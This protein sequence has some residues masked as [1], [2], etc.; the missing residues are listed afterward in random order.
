MTNPSIRERWLARW[1]RMLL[2]DIDAEQRIVGIDGDCSAFGLELKHGAA[3]VDALPAVHSLAGPNPI[4]LFHVEIA[5]G[6][7]CHLSWQPTDG[8]GQ[9]LLVDAT[10]EWERLQR[11]Q[12]RANNADLLNAQLL[13]LTRQLREA[14]R[15]LSADK[16]ALEQLSVA[17]GRL[18]ATISHE[19][20]TPLST[21]VGHAALLGNH[22]ETAVQR[23][24]QVIARTIEHTLGLLENLIVQSQVGDQRLQLKAEPVALRPLLDDFIALFD[25]HA[26]RHG[27]RLELNC[28]FDESQVAELDPS[29][30][31]QVIYNLIGNAFKHAPRAVVVT[32]AAAI[33]AQKLRISIADDGDGV[34]AELRGALFDAFATRRSNSGLGLWISRRLCVAMNGDLRYESVDPHGARFIVELNLPSA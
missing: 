26:R 31:R 32:V 9:W 14:E 25:A 24:A 7:H 15:Q 28:E 1:R 17:R 8:G 16:L 2:I 6:C 12:Q 33:D 10:L 29:A 13:T 34:G 18:L 19:L 4:E 23:S 5:A 27:H 30:L 11:E 20:R 21:L 22:S 3:L